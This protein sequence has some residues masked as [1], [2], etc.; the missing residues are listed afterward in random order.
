MYS[1]AFSDFQTTAVE[2]MYNL[3]GMYYNLF[4]STIA[5]TTKLVSYPLD[6]SLPE[7]ALTT[8]P[9]PKKGMQRAPT[10]CYQVAITS[11]KLITLID[12]TTT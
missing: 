3:D 7:S 10:R 5:M 2:A 1:T 4:H 12:R 11:Q 6:I 8:Q 9:H